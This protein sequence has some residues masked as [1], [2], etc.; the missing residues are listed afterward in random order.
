MKPSAT[1]AQTGVDVAVK[2]TRPAARPG[3]P[4]GNA[5]AQIHIAKAQ[6][7]LDDDTYRAMLWGVARVRSAR[8]LDFA[9]R[10]AVLEH[11]KKCGFKSAP[12]KAPTP[13]RPHNMTHP[14]RGALLGKIEAL[15]LEA[16]RAWA[17]A[18][19]MARKMFSVDKLAFCHEGQLHKLV[20]ALEFDKRRRSR[21]PA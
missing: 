18:D 9:G 14:Q 21:S 7:G 15:L 16:G 2:N 5:L 1:A 13:G 4:R 19:G 11:L 3:Q 17:Y 12:P 10:T 6:L 8:D 20:A